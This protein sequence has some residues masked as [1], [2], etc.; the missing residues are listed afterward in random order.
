MF[1][2]HDRQL[3]LKKETRFQLDKLNFVSWKSGIRIHWQEYLLDFW[4]EE[5]KTPKLHG[6]CMHKEGEKITMQREEQKNHK[7]S[8]EKNGPDRKQERAQEAETNWL[9]S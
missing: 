7:D 6:D 3:L 2:F 9:T 1:M 5:E 8:A 4:I